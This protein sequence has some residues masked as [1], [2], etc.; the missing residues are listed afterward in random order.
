MTELVIVKSKTVNHESIPVVFNTSEVMQGEEKD[1]REI[2]RSV[3]FENYQAEIPLYLAKLLI[4]MNPSEFRF[5][6]GEFAEK[7]EESKAKDGDIFKCEHCGS[8]AKSKAGLTAH[9]RI[10]HPDKWAKKT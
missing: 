2:S 1:V 3:V 10:A 5:G 4:K 9:T 6:D 8:V 7:K